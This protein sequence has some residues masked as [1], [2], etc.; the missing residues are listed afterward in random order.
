MTRIY[1]ELALLLAAIV[2]FGWLV[3]EILMAIK[4]RC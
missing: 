4:L 2:L 1:T 3:Y